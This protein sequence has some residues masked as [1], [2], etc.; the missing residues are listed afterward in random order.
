MRKAIIGS[1]TDQTIANYNVYTSNWRYIHW[2]VYTRITMYIPPIGGIYIV[3][4][5]CLLSVT[6][7]DCFTHET[8][9]R[10]KSV[11]LAYIYISFLIHRETRQF[12]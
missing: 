6:P 3:I 8:L 10:V 1:N 7:D 5:D 9:C 4:R 2:G 11:S 12:Y